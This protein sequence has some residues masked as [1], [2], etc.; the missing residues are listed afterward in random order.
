MDHFRCQWR[1]VL[2]RPITLLTTI[3]PI[4]NQ[5]YPIC[6][7]TQIP[8]P[9]LWVFYIFIHFALRLFTIWN[10]S[11][12]SKTP[13]TYIYSRPNSSSTECMGIYLSSSELC[14][15]LSL[16]NRIFILFD[17]IRCFLPVSHFSFYSQPLFSQCLPFLY[18]STTA[19]INH[20]C[21]PLKCYLKL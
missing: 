16:I 2:P 14:Q 3:H 4:S 18:P 13:R 10:I 1:A 15:F 11:G 19:F 12:C 17:L 8:I 5:T 7:S 20:L 9:W 21:N 6:C